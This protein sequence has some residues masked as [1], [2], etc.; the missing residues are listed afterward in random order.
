MFEFVNLKHSKT[1]RGI[2][3]V[4]KI[5]LDGQPVGSFTQDPFA[6]CVVTFDREMDESRFATAATDAG[7]LQRCDFAEDLLDAAE[8]KMLASEANRR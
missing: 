2:K 7:H 3:V 8:N 1:R 6:A 5:H 4:G